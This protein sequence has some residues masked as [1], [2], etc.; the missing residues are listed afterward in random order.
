MESLAG[1]TWAD[2][3]PIPFFSGPMPGATAMLK[4]HKEL[5]LVNESAARSPFERLEEAPTH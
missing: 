3:D 5:L 4:M 1:R 2:R